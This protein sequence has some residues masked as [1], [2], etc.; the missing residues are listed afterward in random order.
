M[1]G[2]SFLV[3]CYAS[4]FRLNVIEKNI[5]PKDIEIQRVLSDVPD[6]DAML[7]RTFFEMFSQRAYQQ[8]NYVGHIYMGF[9][10]TRPDS[11]FETTV[12]VIRE[13]EE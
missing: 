5:R 11:L 9:G 7:E 3:S 4:G 10:L 6:A 2:R 12:R 1:G 8:R 13:I